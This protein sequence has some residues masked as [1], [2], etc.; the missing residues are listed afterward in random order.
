[1]RVVICKFFN[2]KDIERKI[3]RLVSREKKRSGNKLK[4]F[5]VNEPIKKRLEQAGIYSEILN[6]FQRDHGSDD[7]PSWEKVY[8]L[9]DELRSSVHND[10]SLKYSGVNF[11]TM[12]YHISKY[13]YAVKL[14]NLLTGIKA[15]NWELIII[16]LTAPFNNWLADINSSSIKTVAFGKT[17]QALVTLIRLAWRRMHQGRLIFTLIKNYF[18]KPANGERQSDEAGKNQKQRRV[19]F[20]VSAPLYTRPALAIG[21]ECL[22]NGLAPSFA[23]DD[24]SLLPLLRSGNVLYSVQPPL[25]GSLV[26]SSALTF[27]LMLRR[28]KKHVK[29]FYS[30]KPD[31]FSAEYLCQRT[32]LADLPELC[33]KAISG[34]S[35]LKRLIN[36]ASPDMVCVMPHNDFLEQLAAELAKKYN[37]PTLACSAAWE[38]WDARSFRRHLHADRIAVMGEGIKDIY[39]KSG[40]AEDMVIATGVAHFDRLFNRNKGQDDRVL[41]EHGIDPSKRIIVFGTENNQVGETVEA[42]NGVI[43]AVLKVKDIQLVVKV[44]PGE[45]IGPFQAAAEHYHDPRLHVVKDIDLYALLSSCEL[46]IVKFSTVA[47]EAMMIGKPVVTIN[48]SGQPVP[49]PY[50]EEGA[51]LGVYKFEDIEPAIREV[52]YN[53]ETRSRLK[54]GSYKFVRAWAGEPDGRASLRIVNLMKEMINNHKAGGGKLEA[55]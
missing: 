43:E 5:C 41:S 48:L 24:P 2:E 28:L 55:G 7:E 14:S 52:L 36:G 17:D 15:Q 6:D 44:H 4:V 10:D 12:E 47:L 38:T 46:I 30:A 19:L 50:A 51:A 29:A 11:L 26:S 27:H 37:I 35:F 54:A 8:Q 33:H 42:L 25:F 32:L 18:N 53:E 49:V 16:V 31:E 3:N 40:L 9:S 23:T 22:R 45:G 13:V 34:I 1:M 20:V 39:L 21:E